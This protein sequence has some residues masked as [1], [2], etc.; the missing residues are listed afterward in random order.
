M[1]GVCH[2]WMVGRF[3][4][5]TTANQGIVFDVWGRVSHDVMKWTI[6]KG[7]LGPMGYPVTKGYYPAYLL[8]LVYVDTSY[9]FI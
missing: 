2:V 7:K 4:C 3:F 6:E 8:S 1:G 9:L 5:A